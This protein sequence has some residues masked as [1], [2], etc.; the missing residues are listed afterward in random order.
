MKRFLMFLWLVASPLPNAL[1]IDPGTAQGSLEVNQEIIVL[2]QGYAH[3]HD[4][5]EGLLDRPKELRILLT[6]RK[7]P[8]DSLR[9]IAFL[10][11]LDL[12]KQGQVRGLLI[13]LDPKDHRSI[14]VTLLCP[15][16][17]SGETFLTQT[18]RS[19]GQKLPIELKISRTRVTGEIHHPAKNERDPT[20]LPKLSYAVKFSAP[21]FHEL[22]ITADLKGKAAQDS[23]QAR[24]LREKARALAKGDLEVV[25]RLSSKCANRRAQVSLAEAGSEAKLF[26]GK[27]AAEMERSTRLIRRVVVRGERAVA[28]F[29]KT[30]WSSFA[31]EDGEWKSDD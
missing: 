11:V 28:I 2:T 20:A 17:N 26:A 19:S 21:L 15:P 8:Q 12:A 27:A 23:P 24:V 3:L 10:P 14:L 25:Y 1:A 30:Q 31:Q 13:R 4:N 18:I 5:A 29:S 6:D 9:G 7:V 22:A 16:A